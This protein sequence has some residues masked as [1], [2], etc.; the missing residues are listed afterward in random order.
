MLMRMLL[1]E[2]KTLMRATAMLSGGGG[3]THPAH[4]YGLDQF[5]WEATN[6]WTD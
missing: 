2:V 6:F 1:E 5:F 4:D 3:E